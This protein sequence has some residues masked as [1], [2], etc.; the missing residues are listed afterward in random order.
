MLEDISI[1][2]FDISEFAH[3]ECDTGTN[4]SGSFQLSKQSP[5][6]LCYILIG[7]RI[8]IIR[9]ELYLCRR[10]ERFERTVLYLIKFTKI[11]LQYYCLRYTVEDREVHQHHDL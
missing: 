5:V 11:E 9:R 3:E 4:L 10:Y 6:P 8:F 7:L 2:S 1:T